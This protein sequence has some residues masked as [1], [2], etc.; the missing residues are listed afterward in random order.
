MLMMF[1]FQW[2]L[3]FWTTP[4]QE[5]NDCSSQLNIRLHAVSLVLLI[6][7]I[8]NE[9]NQMLNNYRAEMLFFGRRRFCEYIDSDKS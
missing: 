4:T 1:R 2:I 3:T 9:N 5:H 8:T 6:Y 7:F